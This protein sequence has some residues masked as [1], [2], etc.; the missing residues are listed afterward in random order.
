MKNAIV[1]KFLKLKTIEV[2]IYTFLIMFVVLTV[3]YHDH[4]FATLSISGVVT[5]FVASVVYLTKVSDAFYDRAIYIED[6]IAHLTKESTAEEIEEIR[7][8]IYEL[9]KT[10][11]DAHTRAKIRQLKVLLNYITK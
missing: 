3:I 6:K 9:Q 2:A 8:D 4:F 11:Y 1:Q 5:M 7:N 10:V